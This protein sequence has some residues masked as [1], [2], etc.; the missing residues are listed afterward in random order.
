MALA[1]TWPPQ[2]TQPFWLGCL[3]DCGGRENLGIGSHWTEVE[4]RGEEAPPQEGWRDDG[5]GEDEPH[6]CICRTS[7]MGAVDVLRQP[8]CWLQGKPMR[9]RVGVVRWGVDVQ[10][11]VLVLFRRARKGDSPPSPPFE[12]H[13][14]WFAFVCF[15]IRSHPPP[16][17]HHKRKTVGSGSSGC[18]PSGLSEYAGWYFRVYVRVHLLRRESPTRGGWLSTHWV[19]DEGGRFK[20]CDRGEAVH[21]ATV[22]MSRCWNCGRGLGGVPSQS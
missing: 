17:K 12:V 21:D 14:L 10:K 9:C 5:N 13:Y 6:I 11:K 1:G 19:G 20:N 18:V 22:P 4:E 15:L 2:L 3:A 16:S 7:T 8:H